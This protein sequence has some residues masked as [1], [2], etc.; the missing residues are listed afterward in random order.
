MFDEN[1][2]TILAPY[3]NINFTHEMPDGDC[4]GSALGLAQGLKQGIYTDVVMKTPIPEKYSF[5]P[6]VRE[7]YS[8]IL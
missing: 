2:A 4:I 6:G 5:L 3:K 8:L 7:Y 1:I